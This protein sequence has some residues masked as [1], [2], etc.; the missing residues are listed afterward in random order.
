M[1]KL[2]AIAA[3][4]AITAFGGSALANDYPP[5]GTTPTTVPGGGGGL[6]ETGSDNDN[7]LKIAGGA[8]VAGAGLAVVAKVR[9]RPVA[10]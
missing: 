9:R 7:T 2:A 10:T 3:I 6:P 4:T 8:L 1:R 5:G